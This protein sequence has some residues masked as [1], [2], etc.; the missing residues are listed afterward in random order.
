VPIVLKSGS[1]NLL[2]PSGPAKASNG[3]VLLF[4]LYPP[5]VSAKVPLTFFKYEPVVADNSVFYDFNDIY[6]VFVAF[7]VQQ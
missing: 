2:E 4:L 5:N 3:I 6:I 1:L 7:R